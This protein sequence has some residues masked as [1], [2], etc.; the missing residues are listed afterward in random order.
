[1]RAKPVVEVAPDPALLALGGLQHL[2]LQVLPQADLPDQ[3]KRLPPDRLAYYP[4][5]HAAPGDKQRRP[6]ET[7]GGDLDVRRWRVGGVDEDEVTGR[8][9]RSGKG[10]DPEVEAQRGEG[11]EDEQDDKRRRWFAGRAHRLCEDDA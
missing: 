8:R 4:R 7:L 10:G 1:M 3:A 11:D 9:R 2:L 6:H 5:R